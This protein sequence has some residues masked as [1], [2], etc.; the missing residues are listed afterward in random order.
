MELGGLIVWTKAKD[1]WFFLGQ[2]S[3]SSTSF[4]F[5]IDPFRGFPLAEDNGSSFKTA[6]RETFEESSGLLDFRENEEVKY[7]SREGG[8]FHIRVEF[9]SLEAVIQMMEDFDSNRKQPNLTKEFKK[10]DG[11][12][13]VKTEFEAGDRILEVPREL[14]HEK[15][16]IA[17]QVQE[18]KVPSI[19][20]LDSFARY[21]L[22]R[23]TDEESGQICY[24][25][26]EEITTPQDPED[27]VIIGEDFLITETI[28]STK[29]LRRYMMEKRRRQI[30]EYPED[31]PKMSQN[32]GVYEEE[33]ASGLQN[34]SPFDI[35]E[36]DPTEPFGDLV[37]AILEKIGEK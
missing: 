25:L 3:Y 7:W 1:G 27:M 21:P 31:L 6:I 2:V 29:K 23:K 37:R 13:W 32:L 26:G 8:L 16:R 20:E 10:T 34:L 15:F 14:N 35:W 11:L 28:S 24:L 17:S 36:E 19:V 4:D 18:M 5:K 12:A 9:D 33:L 22:C 30:Q